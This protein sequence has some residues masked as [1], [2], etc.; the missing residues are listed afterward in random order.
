MKGGTLEMSR[1][2]RD[3]LRVMG[4]VKVGKMRMR[5]AAEL[6]AISYR[7]AGRIYRR[8]GEGE[9]RGPLVSKRSWGERRTDPPSPHPSPP[10]QGGERAGAQGTLP[11]G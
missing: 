11:M 6:L 3:R 2:E 10:M 5:K 8:Y 7:Q 9:D 1:G 4:M